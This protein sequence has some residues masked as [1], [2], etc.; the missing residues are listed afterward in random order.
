MLTSVDIC[1]IRTC[2]DVNLFVA[3][4]NLSLSCVAVSSGDVGEEDINFDDFLVVLA[5]D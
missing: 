4:Q 3:P 2:D 5:Q 1:I